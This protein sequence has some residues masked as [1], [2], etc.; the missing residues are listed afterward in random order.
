DRSAKLWPARHWRALV[1]QL[2]QEGLG[3]ALLGAPPKQSNSRYHT[4]E[5]DTAVLEAGAMDLRGRLALPQ[6]AG[7]LAR[8][9]A[10]V[11]VD[12]GLMHMA[13]AVGTP[14]IALFGASPRRIWA[15]PV[16]SIH[17]LEP[18]EPCLL[19]EQNRF[20]NADCL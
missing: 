15:P 19:C 6:V 14:T 1:E 7:A 12:N 20:L 3:V 2:G 13:A 4:G 9:R 16:P 10:F 5:I 18:P 8:A 17:L 11:T